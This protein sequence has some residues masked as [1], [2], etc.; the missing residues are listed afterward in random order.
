MPGDDPKR[1]EP[2]GPGDA[3]RIVGPEPAISIMQAMIGVGDRVDEGRGYI[4]W[5][6]HGFFHVP[7]RSLQGGII[8]SRRNAV[9]RRAVAK[10]P[11]PGHRI[12]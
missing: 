10:T 6:I 9:N 3:E 7:Q 2:L 4:G 8:L 12:V 1:I 5:N 11:L